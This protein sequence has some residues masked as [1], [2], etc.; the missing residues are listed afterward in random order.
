MDTPLLSE[1]HATL[2]TTKVRFQV[3]ALLCYSLAA[4]FFLQYGPNPIQKE[5]IAHFNISNL[6]YSLVYSIYTIPN[7]IICLIAGPYIDRLGLRT[8]GLI[9][10]LGLLIGHVI[11]MVSPIVGSYGV[12]L[13][14]RMLIGVFAELYQCVLFT[15]LTEWFSNKEL[16]VATS[17]TVLFLRVGVISTELIIPRMYEA[18][19]GYSGFKIAFAMCSG[20]AVQIG[21]IGIVLMYNR[22]DLRNELVEKES[23]ALKN[24]TDEEKFQM[25]DIMTL[26]WNF[27]IYSIFIIASFVSFAPYSANLNSLLQTRFSLTP[28]TSGDLIAQ[29]SLFALILGP[30]FGVISDRTGL[31]G[32]IMCGA[33][34]FMSLSHILLSLL[35]QCLE[36]CTGQ[37][38]YLPLF[39]FYLG[40]SMY[41]ANMWPL[42][43]LI[44]T[45]HQRT[46]AITL[47]NGVQNVCFLFANVTIGVLLDSGLRGN[48]AWVDVSRYLGVMNLMGLVIVAG[49]HAGIGGVLNGK[50]GV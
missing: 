28:I 35:P 31:R 19:D 15:A 7:I 11:F 34:F 46:T 20:L 14:G 5:I 50:K 13:A 32:Y 26:G 4:N 9:F 48:G 42:L 23:K 30:I 2:R 21:Q 1:T 17:V 43:K 41:Q 37:E 47:V 8:S 44:T 49:W 25:K 24:I 29:T 39:L 27:M 16:G 33:M 6:E 12:A 40:Y 22:I 45:P 10:T 36:Y 38:T 3:L 18:V